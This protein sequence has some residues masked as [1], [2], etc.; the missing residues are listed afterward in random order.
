MEISTMADCKISVAVFLSK[1]F[2]AAVLLFAR[3]LA[4]IDKR[5]ALFFLKSS[6]STLKIN[7]LFSNNAKVQQSMMTTISLLRKVEL[8]KS[9]FIADN[10]L[11]R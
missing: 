5:V 8:L 10:G 7:K 4:R 9:D 6:V 1:N 11:Y 2:S 3:T